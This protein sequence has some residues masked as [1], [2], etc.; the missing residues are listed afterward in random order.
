MTST[1]T[2]VIALLALAV[3][4]AAMWWSIPRPPDL[5]GER[6]FKTILA[7]M[8]RGAVDARDGD[9]DDWVEAVVRFV[10]YHPAGRMP[11]RKVVRP[12]IDALPGA[13]IAGETALLEHLAKRGTVAERWAWMFDEDPVGRES[14]LADPHDLGPEYEPSAYLRVPGGWG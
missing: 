9:R 8:L 14:R 13:A 10:P 6:W 12:G 7:T 3:A 11:E 1:P 2:L 4:V 5:D